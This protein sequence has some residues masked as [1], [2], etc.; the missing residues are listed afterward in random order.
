MARFQ[1][2][3]KKEKLSDDEINRR[4]NFDEFLAKR[5]QPTKVW[6]KAAKTWSV[7]G[8]AAAVL[9]T[10]LLFTLNQPAKNNP[11]YVPFIQP[12]V[13][14][15]DPVAASFIINTAADT[16]LL[17]AKGS[18]I[19]IP[20]GSFVYPGG[21]PVDGN[22]EL[23]YR[24]LHDPI[25]IMCSGI[26][27]KYDSAGKSMLLE[28][29]GMIQIGAYKNGQPLELAPGKELTV[30]LIS[31]APDNNYNIYYLDTVKRRWEYVSGNTRKNKTCS[32]PLYTINK[33]QEEQFAKLCADSGWGAPVK[34]ERADPSA[35]QFSIDYL[36]DE[37]PELQ[38]YDDIQF[39]PLKGEK[40]FS[41]K[42]AEKTWDDVFIS[43]T[44][45]PGIYEIH[46][47]AEH[48]SHTFHAKAV[49]SGKNYAEVL[50]G[51]E[52][53]ERIYT[54]GLN[55]RKRR[56]AALKDSMYSLNTKFVGESKRTR[57]NDRF[58]AFLL[59]DYT[60]RPKSQLVYRTLNIR[61]LGTWNCDR[62]IMDFFDEFIMKI[63]A[64]IHKAFFAASFHND[65]DGN[66]NLKAAYL[67]KQGVSTAFPLYPRDFANHFPYEAGSID[68]IVGIAN[69]E[70]VYFCKGDDLAQ[71][72]INGNAISFNMRKIDDKIVTVSQLQSFMKL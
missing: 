46:F 61:K 38:A 52:T 59:G 54:A 69:D 19:K 41:A 55:L 3:D 44:G 6:S 28:S 48:E 53:R 12:P 25:E 27:M 8:I 43:R 51:F 37:F 10:V 29:A 39:E 5:P 72:K 24:E 20:N 22:V 1:F 15:F 23:R 26:S 42:L 21:K 67:V 7:A 60:D 47:S 66:L 64:G 45:T 33:D 40:D 57:Y 14:K 68:V 56:L 49:A 4:M 32:E 65:Q 17:S 2:S 18:E 9:A 13:K 34:P 30:Q 35:T 50:A 63:S 31:A 71:A 16:T 36:R 70:N 11:A 62:P 58:N